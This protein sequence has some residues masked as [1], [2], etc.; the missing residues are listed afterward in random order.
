MLVLASKSPRRREILSDAGYRFKVITA[1]T[2]ETVSGLS[3]EDTVMTL[4]RRKALA[5][6]PLC[7]PEDVIIAADTLVF[8]GDRV[9]G[10]PRDR[11]DAYR[12]LK[13][14]SGSS[15]RVL[16][17]ITVVRGNKEITE[18]DETRVIFNELSDGE[19]QRYIEECNPRDKAGAYGIQ[20]LGDSFVRR[21]DGDY[22]NVV[23]L[24][25]YRLEK[26]LKEF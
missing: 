18:Y 17:G 5:V 3:P 2:D 21:I 10:K 13:E 11:R 4:S 26:I 8:F 24:P 12:M 9:L 23:G 7:S 16:T 25:L 20:E 6:R 15:H 14:L 1:D 19:I 22:N